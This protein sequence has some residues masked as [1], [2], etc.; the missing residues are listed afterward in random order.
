MADAIS[1]GPSRTPGVSGKGTLD[2]NDEFAIPDPSQN[3]CHTL[4]EPV[5]Q[6]W[7]RA[8]Q[9]RRR[10]ERANEAACVRTPGRLRQI[11]L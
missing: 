3:R 6:L 10:A 9:A 1:Y 4:S 5:S 8:F 7:R 11:K 2:Y